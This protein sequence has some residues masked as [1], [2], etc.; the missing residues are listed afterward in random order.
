MKLTVEPKASHGRQIKA[1]TALNLLHENPH[2]TRLHF[3]ACTC[4][5]GL[6]FVFRD[7]YVVKV[8]VAKK[9]DKQMWLSVCIYMQQ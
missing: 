8:M 4:I 3:F 9:Y 2:N 5:Q 6:P 7:T 1:Q